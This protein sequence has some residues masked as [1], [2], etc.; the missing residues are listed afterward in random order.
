MRVV[1]KSER[2]ESYKFVSAKQHILLY[3]LKI[4]SNL[5]IPN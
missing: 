1:K 2:H 4:G 5:G 3:R